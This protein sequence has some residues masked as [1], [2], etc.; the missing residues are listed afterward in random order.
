VAELWQSNPL[1]LSSKRM[2]ARPILQESV[3]PDS[4]ERSTSEQVELAVNLTA[5]GGSDE[6]DWLALDEGSP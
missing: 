2:S 5:P 3:L 6:K 1:E 4:D